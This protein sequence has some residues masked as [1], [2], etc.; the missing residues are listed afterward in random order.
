MMTNSKRKGSDFERQI[1]DFL[2]KEV[3]GGKFKRIATSG[4]I[5]TYLNE[6]ALSADVT[7]NVNGMIKPIKIECKVGYGGAEYLSMKREWLNKI[8]EDAE[9]TFGFPMLIGK[10]SGATKATG[11]QV[12]A[13]MA[14]DDFV[15]VMNVI[16]DLQEALD[17]ATEKLNGK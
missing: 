14:I 13:A 10:F 15:Y 11:V 3:R 8:K 2:N 17:E 1:A 16:S 4:A 9:K 6:P 7:G 5:G 12:F